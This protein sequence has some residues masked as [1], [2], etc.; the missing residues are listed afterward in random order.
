MVPL[1]LTRRILCFL[2]L[3]TLPAIADEL[4]ASVASTLARFDLP[5]ESLSVYVRDL[6]SGE[7]VLAVRED[8]PRNPAST[9]KIVTG[10]AAL[11]QLGPAYRWSTRVFASAA[12][13][14]GRLD[15]DLIVVGGGDPYLVEERL[16]RLIRD[17]RVD[18]L[19]TVTGDIVVD[20][21]LFVTPN[22]DRAAFDNEP[23][24]VYNALPSAVLTNFNAVRFLFEPAADA[25]VS[26][27]ADP[28][29]GGLI[30]VN[31]LRTVVRRCRGFRRG[32]ATLTDPDAHIAFDGR[33]PAACERYAMTRAVMPPWQYTGDLVSLLFRSAGGEIGG[34]VVR[35]SLPKD[36]TLL[37]E[38]D[39]VSLAEVVRL[40]NKHSSNLIARQLLLTMAVEAH[41]PPAT[42]AQGAVLLRGWLD[43]QGFDWPEFVIENGAGRSRKARLTARH[44]VDLIEHGYRSPVM[45]EFLAAMAL[46]GEDGT[47]ADRDA[48]PALAGR[49]H[50][51][52]GSLDHVTALAGVF[53][54]EN[55]RRFALAILQN[56]NDA[57]RGGGQTAQDRLLEWLG[58]QNQLGATQ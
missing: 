13:V 8:T 15:G 42:E 19:A 18:G 4:P 36:A 47:L 16:Y 26:V 11:E 21:S 1:T 14:D 39:S 17:L 58:S 25:A 9:M 29:L 20:D 40:M 54:A 43:E 34:E 41:G 48:F 49:A 51:K 55:G 10:L 57:H 28:A 2:A 44:L 5:A 45:P 22:E 46:Y 52:T 37:A 53:H 32:I 24:R 35:G 12:P 33:F 31:R 38:F 23:F 27:R 7:T 50:L 6:E 56:A 3:T 30:I